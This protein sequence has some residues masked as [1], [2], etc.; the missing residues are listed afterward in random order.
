MVK[1][2]VIGTECKMVV[3]VKNNWMLSSSIFN[4][5]VT[6]FCHFW[7]F[8]SFNDLSTFNVEAHSCIMEYRKV[9]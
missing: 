8:K 9:L 5:K 3:D 2:N 7:K 6:L 1:E 4:K